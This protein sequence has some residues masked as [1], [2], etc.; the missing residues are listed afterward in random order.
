MGIKKIL[1]VCVHNSA[2]S[3]MAE[4]FL[5]KY[6]EGKYIAE[7]AGLKEC[8]V[9]QYAIKAMDEIGIDISLN[10]SNLVFDYFKQGRLYH[11]VVKVCDPKSSERCPVFPN[12]IAS[13]NWDI[14]DPSLTTGTEE[15]ILQ[16][17]RQIR[18]SLEKN[19]I[20]WLK[21]H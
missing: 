19:V 6:A 21:E 8:S 11:Y 1:F 12:I 2:R 5:N 10:S 16:T 3:Q 13:Y 14:K 7:S 9:N 18:D 4:A 20:N 15:E 17:V